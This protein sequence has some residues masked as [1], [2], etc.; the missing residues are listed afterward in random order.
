MSAAAKLIPAERL[1][2]SPA[3]LRG[4]TG[5]S[6]SFIY[7]HSRELGGA[8]YG[9]SR[10]APLRFT[11]EGLLEYHRA[12]LPA[13]DGSRR[14]RATH[15]SEAQHSNLTHLRRFAARKQRGRA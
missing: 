6:L 9:T 8:K 12:H 3:E 10:N 4:I 5:L 14:P 15:E 13:T 7:A 1:L 11:M 2:Y